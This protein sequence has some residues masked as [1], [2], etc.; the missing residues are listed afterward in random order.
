MTFQDGQE[1]DKRA[2]VPPSCQGASYGVVEDLDCLERKEGG[3]D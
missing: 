2:V 1:T 3:K